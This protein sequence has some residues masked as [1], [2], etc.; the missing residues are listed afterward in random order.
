MA[1][2][3]QTWIIGQL[4]SDPQA[5]LSSSDLRCLL[6]YWKSKRQSRPMASRNDMDVLELRQL[7]GNLFLID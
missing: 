5:H 7:G 4:T 3:E 2:F 1:V 6:G